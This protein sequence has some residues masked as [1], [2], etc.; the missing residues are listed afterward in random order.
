MAAGVVV[1]V[2][3]WLLLPFA[4]AWQSS[5]PGFVVYLAL[6]ALLA[7][8]YVAAIFILRPFTTA[9]TATL[10]SALRRR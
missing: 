9:E 6:G 8:V 2:L 10:R 1:A 4:Q 7:G 3:A 5:L